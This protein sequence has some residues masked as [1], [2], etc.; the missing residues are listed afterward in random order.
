MNTNE[1]AAKPLGKRVYGS[2][3]HLPGSKVGPGDY[4]IEAGQARIATEKPRDKYDEIIVQEKYDGTN[5]AIAKHNGEILALTRRGYLADSSPFAQHH[6]FARW[7]AQRR[8]LFDGLLREGERLSGEWMAQAHGIRYWVDGS[9]FV[10]F[11]LFIE[12]KR[13]LYNEFS[14]RVTPYFSTPRLLWRGGPLPTESAMFLVRNDRMHRRLYAID[15]PEGVVYRVERKG[16]VDFLCKFV[17]A[18]FVPGCFLP[19]ISGRPEVWN[20]DPRKIT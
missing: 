4:T 8:F 6:Y 11:D 17:R 1:K 12:N 2:I 10:A 16:K 7:V 19:E 20:F 13:A 5:V 15:D 9:P 18:D 14:K 3:P